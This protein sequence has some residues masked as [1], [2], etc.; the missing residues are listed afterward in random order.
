MCYQGACTATDCDA[1]TPEADFCGPNQDQCVLLTDMETN[2]QHC[3]ECD[4][5]CDIDELCVSSSCQPYYPATGCSACP[6]SI[7]G[8]GACCAQPG[9]GQ[10][11]CIQGAAACPQ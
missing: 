11:I 8:N 5:A 2:P 9:T 1:F 7:C 4:R 6:C 3:G 10:L